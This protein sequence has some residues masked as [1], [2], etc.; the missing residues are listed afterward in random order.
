LVVS[1][2]GLK[3]LN[4]FELSAAAA[5]FFSKKSAAAAATKPHGLH[6]YTQGTISE[7]HLL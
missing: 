6:L 2:G 3:I 4:F 5:G 1:G 7:G